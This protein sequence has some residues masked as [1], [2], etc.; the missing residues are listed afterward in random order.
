MEINDVVL[1]SVD[2]SESTAINRQL[3]PL[4]YIL[5]KM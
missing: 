5:V 4:L 2:C 3:K 1:N